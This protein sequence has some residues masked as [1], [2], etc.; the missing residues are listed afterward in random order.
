M[1]IEWPFDLNI[2]LS[3]WLAISLQEIIMT[4][5]YINIKSQEEVAKLEKE[6]SQQSD[7]SE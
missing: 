5:D 7:L 6:T 1:Y 2:S 4:I 3:I